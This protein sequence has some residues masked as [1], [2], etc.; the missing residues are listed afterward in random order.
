[1]AYVNALD[2]AQR[3][4]LLTHLNLRERITSSVVGVRNRYLL[5][6]DVLLLPL[7]AY[8]AFVLRLDTFDVDPYRSTALLCMAIALL[9]IFL[10]Y[11]FGGYSRYWVFASLPELQL[12]LLT[13]A[14]GEF[15]SM[16]AMLVVSTLTTI[17]AVPR[18]VPFI[19]FFLSVTAL[20]G[21]RFL[22]RLLYGLS[23]Q[24]RTRAEQPYAARALIVGAGEAGHQVLGEIQRNPQLGLAIV[25][26]VDD[27]P[28]K[29]GVTIRGVPVLGPT[30]TIPTLVKQQRVDK[31]LIAVPTATGEQLRR[32]AALCRSSR[33]EALI[34]PGVFE[35][36]AG[37]VQ[38]RRFRPVRVE[39]LLA[40]S[41]V[42]TDVSRI[43]A[44][45]SGKVVLITGAGG[46]IGSE[47]CRQIASRQPAMLVLMGHGENSIYTIHQELT[48]S[49]PELT[50]R[51][52]IADTRDVERVDH[53]FA[54]YRPD[55]VFHAAA[56]KH[57][58]LMELN[59]EEAVTNNVGGTRNVL[60]AAVRHGTDTL[61]MISSDKAVNPTSVMGATK[62]I[63]EHLVQDAAEQTGRRFVAVR[64][65][66]VL[67][68]RGSVVPLFEKQIEAGGPITVTHPDIER[69][70]MTI[71]EAVQLVLQAP[72]LGKGGEV[73]VLDM[74]EPVKIVDLAREMIRLAGRE[75]E[76]DIAY[77]GLRP[78][79]KLYEE[80]FLGAEAY[81]HTD[82]EKVLVSPNGHLSALTLP[83]HVDELLR[84]AANG[85]AG[86]MMR[87]IRILVPE[88]APSFGELLSPPVPVT[89]E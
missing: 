35:L 69:Y 49:Y 4:S 52:V 50:V 86:A 47:L 8:L 1:L 84:A 85:D 88:C 60:G 12:I 7:A 71:P 78:G 89:L 33:T 42:R 39:D 13:T 65:G 6:L 19:A 41:P 79:E 74:G 24:R 40:R 70:F 68:S 28:V 73:F 64:F 36:I 54:Q 57:V 5:G 3:R 15:A 83:H 81:R 32:I 21:P 22:I 82:H 27:D 25:G 80:L 56:H 66:N 45:L 46:S 53:I 29:Q 61:V 38:I 48:T 11:V 43:R 9:K 72:A 67:G 87:E 37:K 63:A 34:L 59:P 31:V 20:A 17:P 14:L 10:F 76:V 58:P 23:T 62:R 44:M 16:G 18:S 26:F 30:S 77:T 2:F 55:V 75:G 51:P